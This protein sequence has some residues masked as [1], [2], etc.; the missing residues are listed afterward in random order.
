MAAVTTSAHQLLHNLAD[1]IRKG[2]LVRRVSEMST[3]EFAQALAGVTGEVQEFLDVIEMSQSAAFHS[4]LE[5]VL[6][7][8]TTKVGQAI[9]A[10]RATLYLVDEDQRE[11]WARVAGAEGEPPVE[12]RVPIQQRRSACGCAHCAAHAAATGESIHI[13]DPHGD[14][15]FDSGTDRARG[16]HTENLLCVPVED[17][18]GRVYAVV[19]LANKKEGDAFTESDERRVREFTASLGVLLE[20]WWKMSCTCPPLAASPSC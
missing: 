1:D 15:L 16:V 6:E 17:A 12:S 3:D 14:P 7:A 9:G 8:F 20:A 11:L 19:E 18:N 4:M 10:E 5:Q 2:E 13:D